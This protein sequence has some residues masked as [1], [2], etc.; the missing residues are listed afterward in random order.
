MYDACGRYV[1]GFR[2]GV[3][4]GGDAA[5]RVLAGL[6]IFAAVS[7]QEGPQSAQTKGL[8]CDNHG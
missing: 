6:T 2:A 1:E 8:P 7:E 4:L 5:G 3:Y